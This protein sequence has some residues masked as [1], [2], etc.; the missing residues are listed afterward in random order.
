M[1]QPLRALIV[2]DS[3]DDTLMLVRELKHG[4]YKLTFEQVETAEAMQAALSRQ[5]W[6]VILADY[7]LPLFSGIEAL[8]VMKNGG[9]DL[10]FIIVTGAITDDTAVAAMKAGAH[11]YVMKDNLK[12]LVPAIERELR[13]AQMRQDRKKT[14]KFIEA[15]LKEKETLLK[16]VHHRV[17]N[18]LQ[19]ISSL[20]HL[21][22]G[23]VKDKDVKA[24]LKDSQNRIQ[25]MAM[26]YNELYQSQSL[27]SINMA[28]YIKKLT[29]GLIKSYTTSPSRVTARI[30]PSDVFIDVDMAIPCGLVINELVT[31]S[32]KYA[33]PENGTGQITISIKEGGNQELELVVSDNG[34]GIPE[35]INPANTD[36]LGLKLVTDLVQNQLDGKI[37][38]DRTQGTTFRITFHQA[39]EEK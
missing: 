37:E 27:A 25:S 34:V 36:T 39:K 38:L 20:L 9:L 23:K 5:A 15:S 24:I 1:S 17:K 26:V 35:G 12:R 21:Q 2:E 19:V 29:G 22:A 31:N 4:G 3:E 10:P 6:D 14:E 16:E 30:D 11:D 13:E 8:A 18:N 28:D 33:F 7:R 32:L